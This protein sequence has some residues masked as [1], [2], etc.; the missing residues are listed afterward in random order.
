MDKRDLLK[1]ILSGEVERE[2]L[3]LLIKAAKAAGN[4]MFAVKTY[5]WDEEISPND[6]ATTNAGAFH[7]DPNAPRYTFAELAQFAELGVKV[8]V[9]IFKGSAPYEQ[10]LRELEKWRKW[11]KWLSK[12]FFLFLGCI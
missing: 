12:N 10:I 6:L 5:K 4:T 1:L 2:K 7:D 8:P 9:I 3:P 11:R